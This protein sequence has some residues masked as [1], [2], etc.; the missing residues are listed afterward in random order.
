MQM[1]MLIGLICQHSIDLIQLKMARVN[2]TLF[3]ALAATVAQASFAPHIASVDSF[4]KLKASNASTLY[5]IHSNQSDYEYAPYL[6]DLH[7][8]HYDMGYSYGALLHAE[9]KEMYNLFLA[10][11]ID[12]ITNSS[13]TQAAIK[14]AIEVVCDWQGPKYLFKELPSEFQQEL[15]GLEQAGIDYGT[16]DLGKIIKRVLVL[17][18][19]PGDLQDF[20][21]VLIREFLGNAIADA[22]GKPHAPKEPFAGYCSMMAAWGKRTSGQQLFSGRNLDWQQ[23]TGMNQYKI[24]VVFHPPQGYAHATVGFIPLY[25]AITGMS[26]R[27]ITVHEANLEENR[28][29]FDGFP[30]ALRLRY[31]MQYAT[32]LSQAKTLWESTNNTVGFNHMVA[33]VADAD[34]YARTQQGAGAMV[35]ETMYNYTAYFADNDER[36]LNAMTTN[37]SLPAHLG[38][39]LAT[40]VWRTNHG[41][42][43][44]IRSHFEW[45]EDVKSS[46]VFR[47]FIIHDAFKYYE[48][49]NQPIGLAEMINITAVVG[50]K[51]D[52]R[53]QFYVCDEVPRGSN[54]VS[55]AFSP[56]NL[57]MATAWE[58]NTGQNWR[59]AG[60]SSYIIMDMNKW[61]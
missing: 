44:Y 27:G 3:L 21:L 16:P 7:G 11:V 24:I 23:D 46:T 61:F 28:I 5:R 1:K 12:G 25:G 37:G 33:S 26:A 40:A 38:S 32:N 17:A 45:S 49:I 41:Y 6:L 29:T 39:P 57:T 36:E 52:T 31:I 4:E 48:S 35:M 55:V 53:E 2:L 42:D 51:G 34:N 56:S 9:I 18:N 15:E 54:I 47:Y 59:P 13:A 14:E 19:A 43:P 8:S 50:N 30:W 20:V 60:C 58:R 10:S 22:I